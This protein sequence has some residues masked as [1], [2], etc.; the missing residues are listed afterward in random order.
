MLPVIIS[1]IENPEDRDL[2]ADFYLKYNNLMYCEARKHLDIEEDVEDA[3]YEALA[4]I[5][6]KIDIF[7]GLKLPQ[8]VSYALT[9]VKNISYVLLK[10]NHY[11]SVVAFEDVEFDLASEDGLSAENIVQKKMFKMHIREIWHQLDLEDRLI[12]EQKYILQW[13]DDELAQAL[14]IQTQSVRM[15]LTRA[16]RSVLKQMQ[17]S[18]IT[19]IDWESYE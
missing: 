8:R 12:L 15:R 9:T 13:R 11:L 4:K 5:I 16:K 14:G 6:E 18:G 2:M 7:R 3:V 17:Q 19:A 10:R 1:S